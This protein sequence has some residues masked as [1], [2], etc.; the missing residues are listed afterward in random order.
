MHSYF[1]RI[2]RRLIVELVEFFV[3]AQFVPLVLLLIWEAVNIF[4]YAMLLGGQ[5]KFVDSVHMPLW[6][7]SF[8]GFFK[9][10]LTN[11]RC[12]DWKNKRNVP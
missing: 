3:A 4:A 5:K 8:D 11:P 9:R 7:G 1:L 6:T 2:I 12:S 10:T